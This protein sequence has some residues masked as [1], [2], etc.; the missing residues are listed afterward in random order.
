MDRPCLWTIYNRLEQ[1]R[2]EG[3][4]H[5]Q[6]EKNLVKN[7]TAEIDASISDRNTKLLDKPENDTLMVTEN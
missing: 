1:L 6:L 5:N 3:I 2:K 7:G 4:S